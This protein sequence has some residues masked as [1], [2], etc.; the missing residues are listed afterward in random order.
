MA[1]EEGFEF[2]PCDIFWVES[3]PVAEDTSK[4]LVF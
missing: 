3:L 4:K 1:T 2:G